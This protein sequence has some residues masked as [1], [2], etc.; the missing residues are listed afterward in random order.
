LPPGRLRRERDEAHNHPLYVRALL[1]EAE[2]RLD[3]LTE[4]DEDSAAA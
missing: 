1:D 3:H 2:C 4:K